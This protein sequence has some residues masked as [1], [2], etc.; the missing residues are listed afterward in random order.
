MDELPTA[1][2]QSR[3][4]RALR[5]GDVRMARTRSCGL[6]TLATGRERRSD[7]DRRTTSADRSSPSAGEGSR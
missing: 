6:G 1:H 3:F 4:L 5:R 7:R 2:E